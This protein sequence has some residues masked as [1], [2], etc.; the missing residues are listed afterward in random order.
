[1]QV[2]LGSTV[3]MVLSDESVTVATVVDVTVQTG[4]AVAAT[5]AR[6]H[7]VAIDTYSLMRGID[8][9]NEA[10]VAGDT[11]FGRLFLATVARDQMW[12]LDV[13]HHHFVVTIHLCSASVVASPIRK[14]KLTISR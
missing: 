11:C 10:F 9:T 3:A 13:G 12:A 14:L 6:Q 5:S 4:A 7:S 1:V 8:W 2:A